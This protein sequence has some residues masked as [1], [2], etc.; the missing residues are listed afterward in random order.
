MTGKKLR[1]RKYLSH[2]KIGN[3][4][5]GKSL[6][7]ENIPGFWKHAYRYFV[8]I[9]NIM[10]IYIGIMYKS[11]LWINRYYVYIAGNDIPG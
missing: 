6:D 7:Q 10:Y 2:I 3:L 1:S 5:K 11:V 9:G 8:Y 4:N